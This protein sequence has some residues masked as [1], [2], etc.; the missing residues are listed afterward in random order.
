[1]TNFLLQILCYSIFRFMCMFCRSLFVLLYFFFWPLCCLSF[2]DLRILI[3]PVASKLVLIK[4]FNLSLISLTIYLLW[5][6][7][8][9]KQLSRTNSRMFGMNRE[10]IEL[11][12]KQL[13]TFVQND[14]LI[15]HYI[16]YIVF[17]QNNSTVIYVL[18]ADP[19]RHFV[20]WS[21]LSIR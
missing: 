5:V 12:T 21:T 8:L 9:I 2:F 14:T 13:F 17:R 15:V 20:T 10:L 19:A 18:L 16:R 6:Y 3:T 4:E 1:M 7:Y 11:F